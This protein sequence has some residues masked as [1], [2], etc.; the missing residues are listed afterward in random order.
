MRQDNCFKI[1]SDNIFGPRIWETKP[2]PSTTLGT[3]NIFYAVGSHIDY[4]SGG[5]TAFIL[6]Y[7]VLDT[8]ITNVLKYK[9]LHTDFKT[10][11]TTN[12]FVNFNF[13]KDSTNLLISGIIEDSTTQYVSI[14][15]IDSTLTTTN[16][17]KY[18]KAKTN[19]T[20]NPTMRKIVS[21]YYA[22]GDKII[23][24]VDIKHYNTSDY[25]SNNMLYIFC[26][27]AADGTMDWEI[28]VKDYSSDWIINYKM[29]IHPDFKQLILFYS[30]ANYDFY[31]LQF[32]DITNG[33]LL[34]NTQFAV[35]FHYDLGGVGVFPSNS[36]VFET[37]D[38]LLTGIGGYIMKVNS[39]KENLSVIDNSTL[40]TPL[41]GIYYNNFTLLTTTPTDFELGSF[42]PAA[43]FLN[44]ES[45]YEVGNF[46]YSYR[47]VNVPTLNLLTD[48]EIGFNRTGECSSSSSG[49]AC[50]SANTKIIPNVGNFKLS[51]PFTKGGLKDDQLN[52]TFQLFKFSK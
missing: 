16:W 29:V 30:N 5:N 43:D 10:S 20:L 28:Q 45:G 33:T 13:N 46:A 37:N 11:G 7:E 48:L 3:N 9:I 52:V 40:L 15:S 23:V 14:L 50:N 4:I 38:V 24:A 36:S 51:Q 17:M 42:S 34:N 18:V 39:R 31:H 32:I 12:G 44:D 2:I 25:S 47:D 22:D 19:S 21:E 27:Q 49:S 6:E 35:T 41:T 1:D 26:V 8:Y